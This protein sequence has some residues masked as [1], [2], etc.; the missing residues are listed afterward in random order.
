MCSLDN[1]ENAYSDFH[2][3]THQGESD[4]DYSIYY[5]EDELEIVKVNISYDE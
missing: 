3:L 1:K 4:C 5:N 2:N